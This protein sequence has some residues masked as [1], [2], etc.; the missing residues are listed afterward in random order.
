M[1]TSF[2]LF[3]LNDCILGAHAYVLEI[4][5]VQMS[6]AWVYTEAK[7]LVV[8]DLMAHGSTIIDPGMQIM[9]YV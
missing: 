6:L 3:L 9:I 5:A 1:S 8:N 2:T 7:A 4:P